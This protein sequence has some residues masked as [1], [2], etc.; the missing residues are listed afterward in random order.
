MIFGQLAIQARG[1]YAAQSQ[2]ICLMTG[3]RP[4]AIELSF[5][6]LILLVG[7]YFRCK[8]QFKSEH[9]TMGI[10]DLVK[11][12]QDEWN[13]QLISIFGKDIPTRKEWVDPQS[14]ARILSKVK[15]G[16]CHAF[17]PDYG[18]MDFR[19]CNLNENNELEISSDDDGKGI[20]TVIS[21]K[22]LIFWNPGEQTHEANFIIETNKLNKLEGE[23]GKN[24]IVENVVEVG[25]KQYE[26]GFVWEYGELR[27]G[28]PLPSNARLLK[29]YLEEVRFAIFGRGSIYNQ[30][31][32]VG[33]DA[34]SA[35]HND[36]EKFERIVSEMAKL[37]M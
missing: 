37:S 23:L 13:E 5:S 16:A 9:K 12:Q 36:P 18:G 17:Y 27:N 29:R 35:H 3:K 31:G 19:W 2:C 20:V 24:E 28:N 25:D 8:H 7:L 15:G 26:P 10:K 33:F 11:K 22:R 4:V 34:Y 14:I 1:K 30:P 6:I 21:P 32:I